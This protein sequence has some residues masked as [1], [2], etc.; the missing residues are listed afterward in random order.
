MKNKAL[1]LTLLFLVVSI[2]NSSQV[3]SIEFE[4]AYSI[5][6]DDSLSITAEYVPRDI[7]VA[8]YNETNF[9]A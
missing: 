7:R 2:L 9:T 1:V 3:T 5:S 8:I 6:I 4:S